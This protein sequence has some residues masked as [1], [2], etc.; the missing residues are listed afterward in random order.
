M[1]LPGGAAMTMT[2]PEIFA[3]VRR[4]LLSQNAK[5]F[6]PDSVTC[7]YRTPDGK[8]CAV[9]C[10]IPDKM[11]YPEMEGN[12]IGDLPWRFV[13]YFGEDNIDF[14]GDLQEIHDSYEP[15]LW[16]ELLDGIAHDHGLIPE[17]DGIGEQ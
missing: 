16:A 1:R 11:Y 10:L 2:K 12:G 13:E 15:A 7:A 5:A 8:K 4:H 6:L 17:Q 9:G 3:K 14:L